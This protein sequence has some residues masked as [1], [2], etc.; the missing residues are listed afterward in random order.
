MECQLLHNALEYQRHRACILDWQRK[1]DSIDVT[2][3]GRQGLLPSASHDSH[4]TNEASTSQ[5]GL[6]L[7]LVQPHPQ[8]HP[9]LAML[10]T[11]EHH[12]ISPD[13]GTDIGI[14]G[15]HDNTVLE[16]EEVSVAREEVATLVSDKQRL[17][18]RHKRLERQ[19][20]ETKTK[21]AEVKGVSRFANS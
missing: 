21:M 6:Q 14:S 5:T 19:L 10:A 3:T 2:A 7:P 20:K 9:Q 1:R 12:S 8:P 16:P 15:N 13:S 18:A 4:V 17:E 11:G